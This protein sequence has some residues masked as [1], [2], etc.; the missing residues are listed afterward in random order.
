MDL[1]LY[2]MS[3]GVSLYLQGLLWF[4]VGQHS[5]NISLIQAIHQVMA[6]CFRKPDEY[7]IKPTWLMS[8]LC[9]NL[10]MKLEIRTNHRKFT[11]NLTAATDIEQLTVSSEN[12]ILSVKFTLAP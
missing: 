4:I 9:S 12:N 8:K 1:A 11:K 3:R 10:V 5:V 7:L 6:I 2:L